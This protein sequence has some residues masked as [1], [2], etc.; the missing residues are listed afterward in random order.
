MTEVKELVEA[1]YTILNY[2]ESKKHYCPGCELR[3]TCCKHITTQL[4]ALCIS[5]HLELSEYLTDD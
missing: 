5:A 1:F 4:T 3:L 2:C